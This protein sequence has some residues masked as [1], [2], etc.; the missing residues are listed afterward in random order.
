M[1][2]LV[3]LLALAAI[4]AVTLPGVAAAPWLSALFV[5]FWSYNVW[6]LYVAPNL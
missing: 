6:A 2:M 1:D 4:I 5:V 3:S